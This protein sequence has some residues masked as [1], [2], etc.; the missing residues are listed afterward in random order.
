MTDWLKRQIA[1]ARLWLSKTGGKLAALAGGALA[2][3]FA[4]PSTAFGVLAFLPDG[5]LR[6]LLA[7]GIWVATILLTQKADKKDNAKAD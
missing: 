7:G 2:V 1:E 4:D 5:P 3:A 6:L